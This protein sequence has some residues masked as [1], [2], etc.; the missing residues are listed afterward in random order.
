MYCVYIYIIN[1]YGMD[2]N[3][4]WNV[5][6]LVMSSNLHPIQSLDPFDDIGNVQCRIFYVTMSYTLCDTVVI[7]W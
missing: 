3:K 1:I 6:G 7:S 4:W 2:K 5:V